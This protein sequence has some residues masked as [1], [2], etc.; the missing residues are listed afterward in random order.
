MMVH[1][2]ICPCWAAHFERKDKNQRVGVVLAW[3][4]VVTAALGPFLWGLL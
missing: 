2:N 1:P 4:V 3:V